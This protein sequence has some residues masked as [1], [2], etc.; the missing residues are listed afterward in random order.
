MRNAGYAVAG[1]LAVVLVGLAGLPGRAMQ[2]KKAGPAKVQLPA[3]VAKAVQDNF[4]NAEIDV[5]EVEHEGGIALYDIEFK[6]GKG[7]IEV[8]A[9]GTVIDLAVIVPMSAVPKAALETIQKAAPGATVK[10]Y[11][12]SEVRSEVKIEGGKGRIVKLP[13]PIEV[14]E[15]ELVEGGRTGEIQVTADGKIREA[16]KWEGKGEEKP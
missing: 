12:K 2:E 8:S 16:L 11:E 1:I 9:D 4:P 3:A 10:Q 15:A 7:E 14:Y 13:V 6:A 5:V